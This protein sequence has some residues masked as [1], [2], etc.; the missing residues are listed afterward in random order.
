MSNNKSVAKSQTLTVLFIGLVAM[1]L[2]MGGVITLT[3]E[4]IAG[5]GAFFLAMG[6]AARMLSDGAKLVFKQSKVA[7]DLAAGQMP[8]L[9][10]VQ[11]DADTGQKLL[12]KAA[13]AATEAG[14]TGE[15]LQKFMT[16]IQ[17]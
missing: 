5:I 9:A 3:S 14:M 15:Q 8:D 4:Q 7:Q 1:G 13:Q 10:D 11:A 17:K 2:E 12:N 6:G 16:L